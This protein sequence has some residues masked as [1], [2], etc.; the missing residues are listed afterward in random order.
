V[1]NLQC[2]TARSVIGQNDITYLGAIRMPLNGTDTNFADGNMTGRIVNGHVRFFLY[3]NHTNTPADAVYE[4]EDPGSGYNIDYTQAPRATMV[5]NWG[6][7]YHGK[8][9]S[10]DTDGSSVNFD[11]TMAPFGLYWNENTQLL[12]WTYADIYNVTHRPDWGMGATSLD[13]P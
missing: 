6:D 7:I 1:S 11:A 9:T 8:R 10:W 5:T 3:G 13:D 4:I 2:A 12:Y